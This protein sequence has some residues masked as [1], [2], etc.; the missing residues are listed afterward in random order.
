MPE[1]ILNICFRRLRYSQIYTSLSWQSYKW[2]N[3]IVCLFHRLVAIL[4]QIIGLPECFHI[5]NCQ[6][7]ILVLSRCITAPMLW[8]LD[9]QAGSHWL[10]IENTWETSLNLR[11]RY[12]EPVILTIPDLSGTNRDTIPFPSRKLTTCGDAPQNIY[13]Q[14]VTAAYRKHRSWKADGHIDLGVS[15]GKSNEE[16]PYSSAIP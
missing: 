6:M 3:W 12:K 9:M 4:D 16:M 5:Q 13:I 1:Q 11:C 15:L 10:V 14:C 2:C 8:W 7:G